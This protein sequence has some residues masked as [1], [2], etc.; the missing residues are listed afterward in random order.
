[1]APAPRFRGQQ[2]RNS[3]LGDGKPCP[4]ALAA[5]AAEKAQFKTGCA[6]DENL[7]QEEAG[8]GSEQGASPSL[9]PAEKRPHRLA[10]RLGDIVATV[11]DIPG[12]SH[13]EFLEPVMREIANRRAVIAAAI[14]P[15]HTDRVAKVLIATVF[16]LFLFGEIKIYD[17]ENYI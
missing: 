15:R 2:E 5:I 6:V 7:R 11:R 3:S 14:S 4:K 17:V 9:E 12:L 1:M 13:S 10:A 8:L 16:R